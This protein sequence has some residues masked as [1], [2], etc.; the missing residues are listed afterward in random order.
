[1]AKAKPSRHHTQW[2]AQFFVAG[3]LSRRGYLAVLAGEG[4]GG[5][6]SMTAKLSDVR[7]TRQE[8][9]PLP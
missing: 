2:A 9:P 6:G 8:A 5:H 7:A 1:M 3:E 4:G